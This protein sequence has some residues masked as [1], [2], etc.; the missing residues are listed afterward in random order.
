MPEAGIGFRDPTEV[1]APDPQ[2]TFGGLGLTPDSTVT[3]S[4]SIASNSSFRT[5]SWGDGLA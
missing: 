5:R 2:M 3:F 1:L 4:S